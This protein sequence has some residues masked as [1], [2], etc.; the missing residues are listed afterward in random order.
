MNQLSR[1]AAS[2]CYIFTI[3]NMNSKKLTICEVKN[4]GHDKQDESHR[5]PLL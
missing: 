2:S 1:V 3:Q 4:D 5:R